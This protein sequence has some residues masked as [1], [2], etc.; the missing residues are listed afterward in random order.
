M[1]T[2]LGRTPFYEAHVAAGARLVDFGGWEL[3]VS[4]TGIQQEHRAVRAAVGLFD[5]SHM[6]EILVTGPRAVEAIDHLTSNDPGTVE[7]GRSQYTGILNEAGGF[8]DDIFIY[9]LDPTTWLLCVNASNRAKDFS[10]LAERNPLPGEVAITDVSDRWAQVAIQGPRGVAVTASLTDLPVTDL[11]RGG[12]AQGTFAGVPGCWL[13]R[14]GYT[15]ED[16]FEVFVPAGEAP[17]VWDRIVLAGTSHGLVPVGLGAR[18]TLRLEVKNVLYGNDISADTTPYEAR[19]GWITRLDKGDFIGREALVAQRAAGVPRFLSCL[20]VDKRI[21]RPHQA[22]LADGEV[23]GE[24][25]S[26]TRSPSLG[27][28]IAL[29]YVARGHGRPGTRLQVDVRGRIAEATV[30]KPPFYTRHPA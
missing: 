18:D 1:A 29:G 4:Y 7:V 8:V 16:G 23:I 10:W 19:L 14:T 2:A 17:P 30:V 9:R 24:V 27:T 20:V 11:P 26:G 15:G 28:N 6:G 21:A 12:I 3:P 22:I 13:A 5:V 25:T